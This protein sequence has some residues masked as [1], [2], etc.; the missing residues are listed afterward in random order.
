MTSKRALLAVL[1][2]S[3]CYMRDPAPAHPQLGPSGGYAPPDFDTASA[4]TAWQWA[5]SDAEA[6][7]HASFPDDVPFSCFAEVQYASDRDQIIGVSA[8]AE[9]CAYPQ[10]SDV[11]KLRS[12]AATYERVARG[13]FSG[14]LPLELA[15]EL[16]AEV[17]KRAAHANARTLTSFAASVAKGERY[18]YAMAGTFGYGNAEQNESKLL[19]WFPGDDC[20]ELDGAQR[21]LLSVNVI[22]AR[23]AA[24]AWNVGLSPLVSVSG[25]AV[26]GRLYE[27]FMLGHLAV[28]DGGVPPD[29]VLY[30]PCADHTH[31]NVRNTGALMKGFGAR[32]AY[33]VT[34]DFIQSDYM[35][36]Y[37]WFESIGGSIDQ[38]A[39]RDWGHL[40]GAWRQ[41]SRGM[42]AGFW[43]TPYRFWAEPAA[44]LG[45]FSCVGDA[46][47]AR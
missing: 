3:S 12:R 32:T 42:S 39:L 27:A 20:I 28:C 14:K 17:R 26:H 18:P 30:D 4:C 25:G 22:R 7:K 10:A 31:T 23:R 8:V 11:A 15:C 47:L 38:R 29:R 34:D 16:P 24:E 40:V 33:L 5:S 46:P 41:A 2:L 36:D 6:S 45:S 44:G 9:A 13:D 21:A 1:A 35:Q 43:Y 19:R 37:V